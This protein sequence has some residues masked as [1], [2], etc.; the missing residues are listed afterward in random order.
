M[1]S[2]NSL[3]SFWVHHLWVFLSIGNLAS[4]FA[5][6]VATSCF[7]YFFQV[8]HLW[9]IC[10]QGFWFSNDGGL[11]HSSWTCFLENTVDRAFFFLSFVWL[12]CKFSGYLSF[13]DIFFWFS[14]STSFFSLPFF[15]LFPLPVFFLKTCVCLL[16]FFFLIL[17][18]N[19]KN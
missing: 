17:N 14:S 2:S 12:L 4:F 8:S 5:G 7:F 18:N 9:K 13:V 6:N 19:K 15:L 1:S 10:C 11:S 16:L 3:C